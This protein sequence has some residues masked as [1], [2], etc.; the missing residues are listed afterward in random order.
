MR[1]RDTGRSRGFG[2]VTYSNGDDGDRAIARMNGAV[3]DGK[4]LE[5]SCADRRRV[6]MRNVRCTKQL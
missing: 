1:D 6:S 4:T 3:L 2:I 5:V